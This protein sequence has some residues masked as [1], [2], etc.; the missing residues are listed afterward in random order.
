MSFYQVDSRQLR[1]KKDELMSLAQRFRQAKETL[2]AN[3]ITLRSM[4][5]GAANEN[6]HTQFIKSAGQMD[7][8]YEVVDKYINVIEYIANR[9]D[10]AEQK[11]LGRAN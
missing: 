4:W 7:A 5:E 1:A 10:Q 9:Y 3:E 6:F 8:F 11:N 2:C